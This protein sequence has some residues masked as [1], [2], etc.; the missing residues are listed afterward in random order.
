MTCEDGNPATPPSPPPLP[1][2]RV[3]GQGTSTQFSLTNGKSSSSTAYTFLITPTQAG[4]IIIPA[5][6]VQI[7]G[8]T[9]SSEPLKLTVMKAGTSSAN[10][11][12][13]TARIGFVKLVV[14]K[15]QVYLGEMLPLE[16]QVYLQQQARFTEMPH[17]KE[18]G[19]TLGKMQQPTQ[20]PTVFN[21][22]RYEVITFKNFVV[23]AKAGKIDIGPASV[24][25]NVPRPDSRRT[26]FGEFVD[27]EPATLESDPQMLEVLPLPK[28]NVPPGFSGAVGNY[29][30]A[31]NVSPT[32]VATG[33]P[34]TV[35]AQISGRGSLD[36]LTL[37]QQADWNQFKV[38]PPTS[39]VQFADQLGMSGIKT[40]ALTVVPESMAIKELPPFSFSY[41]DPDQKQYRTLT[42]PAV[43]L[44]VRPSAASLPPP[45]LANT[46]T[47]SNQP[48]AK[49]ILHIKP[50]LGVLSQIQPPLIQ[51]SWFIGLQGVPV[52]AWISLLVVRKQKEK[53][54]NN[55]RLRRQRQVEKIVNIGLGELRQSAQANEAEAFYATVF[56]LLQEQI[57]ER[58]D[59]P[60]SAITESVVEER[61]RPRNVPEETLISVHDLFQACNQA[62]YSRHSSNEQLISLIPTVET[63][64]NQLRNIPA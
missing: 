32:N 20:A 48:P 53:L 56:R 54:A 41:F 38:Y 46:G 4:E 34:I 16:I 5:I 26:I 40:F 13:A 63:T 64:L 55:P 2:S 50:R 44:T 8:Q 37:P 15:S 19:F 31:V 51:R 58:L 1:N 30:M 35:K 39:D 10:T 27:W 3:S 11:N 24:I 43:P 23:P 18:E 47:E 52:L 14:P 22:R 29:S 9:L 42:Q 7:D 36:S 28:E 21:N 57:G 17:F 45:N 25:L 12:A 33:D 59:V 60:A 49:D 62:R 61:L 6:P